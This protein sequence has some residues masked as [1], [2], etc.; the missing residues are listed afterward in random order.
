LANVASQAQDRIISTYNRMPE[1]LT[2][3]LIGY[4]MIKLANNPP[5]TFTVSLY[6]GESSYEIQVTNTSQTNAPMMNVMYN[7]N[8]TI[9]KRF[10]FGTH[11]P[12]KDP[13]HTEVAENGR[14]KAITES[15]RMFITWQ[16]D[17]FPLPLK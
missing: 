6:T 12:G 17:M 7:K 4:A 14:A 1:S 9:Q 10:F 5:W 3:N 13:F 11:Y 8:P 2:S 16:D 15:L